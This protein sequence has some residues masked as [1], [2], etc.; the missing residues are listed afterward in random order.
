MPS[1]HRLNL[2]RDKG[3]VATNRRLDQTYG[4]LR[5]SES[6]AHCREQSDVSGCWLR[7]KWPIGWRGLEGLTWSSDGNQQ[8]R[9]G[10]Y[11]RYR[12]FNAVQATT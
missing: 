8:S 5:L 10:N 9:S 12:R 7:T 1:T 2:E 3:L 11:N 4:A 6:G